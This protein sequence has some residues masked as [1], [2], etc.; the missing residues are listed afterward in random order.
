HGMTDKRTM[1]EESIR[2]P[3]LVRYPALVK[4]G[5]VVTEQVL[6]IDLAPSVLD[7]C[8]AKPL[9]NIHGR[10]WKPLL[11]G[12]A[13]GWRTAWF[14]E[15]NYEKQFPYTPN[16]RGVRTDTWK[17]VHYP[18]GDGGPDRHKAELYNLKDD[19]GESKNLIDDPAH[20]DTVAM[21]K[22]ELARLM[23]ETGALPDKMPL[24]EG[25]KKE[26]P[27]ESIR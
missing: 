24:D 8:S 13:A 26:L 10:S 18:H 2:V 16:V 7:V 22:K 27:E 20:A 15:Y 1:H 3:L 23:Q 19:P 17:Y 21:L 6:N 12:D 11:A 4:A 5:T 25:V 9:S 14:Y